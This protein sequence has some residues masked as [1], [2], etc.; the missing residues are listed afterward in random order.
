VACIGENRRAGRA[1]VRMVAAR[2]WRETYQPKLGRSNTPSFALRRRV[3]RTTKCAL[4]VGK[5]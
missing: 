1:E 3:L 4:G 5:A 2:I